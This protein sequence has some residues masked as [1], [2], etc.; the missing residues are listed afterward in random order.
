MSTTKRREDGLSRSGGRSSLRSTSVRGTPPFLPDPAP[1]RI[2]KYEVL[3][4]LGAGAMGVVYRCRQPGLD[5]PVAIK[6]LLAAGHA[7][8]EHVRRFE[9]EARAAAQLSHPNVV[10]VYDVG[11]D[12]DLDYLV[13][14]YVQGTSLDRLIG[15]P[16]LT[17]ER[18]LRLLVHLAQALDAAHHR[19]IVHRDV[20][21][22]NI[23]IDADGRPKLADFGLAKALSDRDGLSASGDLI[24]TPRYMSPEQALE[25]P[26]D[27]DART[28][29]YSLG[30]VLYEMLA[31]RPPFDGA[32]AV[33]T[34][35]KVT[36]EEPPP[37]RSLN[38]DVPEE[39][40]L[41]CAKAMAKDRDARFLSAGAFAEAIQTLLLARL[42]G[43]PEPG[44]VALPPPR[45][46]RHPLWRAAVALGAAG[47]LAA[48]VLG[49]LRAWPPRA[50]EKN[51]EDDPAT[52]PLAPDRAR[53]LAEVRER[54]RTGPGQLDGGPGRDRVKDV[55][56]DLTALLKQRP[57]DTEA[58]FW[59]A[60]AYRR[61]GECL[62]AAEDLNAVCRQEPANLD[63]VRER[64]LAGY[65]VYIL[66]L[67]NLNEPALRPPGVDPLREDLQTLLQGGDE[68]QKHL[69]RVI[70]A[71]ARRDYEGA[72]GLA[73]AKR[74][75]LKDE[76]PDVQM[77]RADALFHAADQVYAEEQA[78]DGPEAK[79]PKKARRD[80]LVSA[81]GEAL[82]RGL[83]AN[84][85]HTGLLFLK[86]NSQQQRAVWDSGGE[87]ADAALKRQRPLFETAL[88]QLRRATLRLGPD[89]PLARAVLLSNAGRDDPAHEQL[90]DALSL[91]SAVRYLHTLDAWLQLRSPPDGMLTP[92][93]V[94]RILGSLRPAFET[95][96]AEFNTYFVRALA[97]AA[98][99]RWEEARADLRQCRRRLGTGP[100]PTG[101]PTYAEW[102]DLAG[103]P[104]SKFLDCT[105]NVLAWHVSTPVDLRIRLGEDALKL[106][107]QDGAA[108]QDAL[109][110][111]EVKA[112]K[113]QGH[114]RLARFF[115]EK[116]DRASALSHVKTALELRL[117]DITPKTLRE[118]DIL[119]AWNNDETFMALYKQFEPSR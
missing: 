67:G 74:P 52:A 86:A 50:G 1:A 25:R 8:G 115:A 41:V 92:E 95:P 54:L 72:A 71:L 51:A 100:L 98:A 29:V 70:E 28:D 85:S 77:V 105:V 58:L 83:D 108:P 81:A 12:G 44:C 37:L 33:A 40:A 49:T 111:D 18:T 20:K 103:G 66:Y 56:E 87:D 57:A 53:L 14:E 15:T 11:R 38:P 114:L 47:L 36:D 5:R 96:P 110:A 89:T 97:L 3:D 91:G 45:R 75:P 93:N 46:T 10:Q 39:V 80:E 76:T 4:R 109:T 106:L 107:P 79:E 62:A 6:V 35:R 101:V 61:V 117:P 104:T 90:Q 7:G 64:L 19:G 34:L 21:P 116:D 118:D 78:A 24:G 43:G 88:N 31:G 13:M 112:L 30:V 55:L 22:S 27:I 68:G 9:R 16:A 42:F 99:G 48:A 73:R 32:T 2:G 82:R 113:G 60:R 84:P 63:A 102:L 69:A 23:L 26:D 17:V 65:Q 94:E 59:R 119:K